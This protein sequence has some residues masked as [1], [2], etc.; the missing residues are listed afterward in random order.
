LVEYLEAQDLVALEPGHAWNLDLLGTTLQ[1]VFQA[2]QRAAYL[3]TLIKQ[4]LDRLVPT[5]TAAEVI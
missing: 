4:G 3:Q 5:G 2:N 1:K